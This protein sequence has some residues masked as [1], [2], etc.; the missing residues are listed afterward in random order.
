M[1]A[2]RLCNTT[3]RDIEASSFSDSVK[4]AS[5]H[6]TRKNYDLT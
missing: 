1:I 5:L 3:N 6:P 2:T 4:I